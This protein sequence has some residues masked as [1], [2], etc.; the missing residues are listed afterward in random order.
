MLE[1][2]LI[3]IGI[4]ILLFFITG[5]I[6]SK[7]QHYRYNKEKQLLMDQNRARMEEKWKR[8]E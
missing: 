6:L 8:E 3:I 4:F 1:I 2:I 5:R 7:L